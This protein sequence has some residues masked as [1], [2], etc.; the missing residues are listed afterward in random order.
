MTL[1]KKATPSQMDA[2]QGWVRSLTWKEMQPAMALLFHAQQLEYDLLREMIH[3]QVPP[4][5]PIHARAVPY[6]PASANACEDGRLV[7]RRHRFKRPRL[8]QWRRHGQLPPRNKQQQFA[9]QARKFVQPDGER[10]SLGCTWEQREADVALVEQSVFCESSS[11]SNNVV[12]LELVMPIV[13]GDKDDDPA[14]T[15]RR[16]LT[17]ASRGH[18]MSAA[19]TTGKNATRGGVW[20]SPW[21]DPTQ[22]WFSLPM[23]LASR[24]ELALWDAFWN[25]ATRRKSHPT[26]M[27]WPPDIHMLLS[28]TDIEWAVVQAVRQELQRDVRQ[29]DL[30]VLM[31]G[32]VWSFLNDNSKGCH[33]H[34][35]S[36]LQA[37]GSCPLTEIDTPREHIRLAARRAIQERYVAAAQSSLLLQEEEEAPKEKKNARRRKKR[38]K[39]RN[40]AKA[41]RAAPAPIERQQHQPDHVLTTSSSDEASTVDDDAIQFP[42][43]DTPIRERNRN[44][45][46]ALAIMD[47]VLTAVF[48]QVDCDDSL[49]GSALF[50]DDDEQEEDPIE[51]QI[52]D[53]PPAI[54]AGVSHEEP[55]TTPSIFAKSSASSSCQ[56]E[57]SKDSQSTRSPTLSP[58][59]LS[60]S[61]LCDTRKDSSAPKEQPN[62]LKLP[63]VRSLSSVSVL[64]LP[65]AADLRNSHHQ[66]LSVHD[67]AS[68]IH[69]PPRVGGDKDERT[70]TLPVGNDAED[71]TSIRE[72]RDAYRDMC[73]TMGAEVAKLKNMLAAQKSITLTV[74][75]SPAHH[76]FYHRSAASFDPESMPSPAFDIVPRA[77]TLAAMSD[78]GYLRGEHESQASEDD[79]VRLL[80][81]ER[82]RPSSG[83]TLAGSD[84]SLD[85]NG[86]HHV[87]PS[88]TGVSVT[89]VSYDPMSLLHGGMQ[90]RLTRDMQHFLE[91]VKVQLQ[92]QDPLRQA[93]IVRMTRLVKTVWPRAQVKLYGSLVTGLSLPSSDLDFVICLP[94][95]HKN[96]LAVAPGVLEGQNAI[97]QTSQKLLARTLSGELWVDARSMKLIERTPVPVIKVSTKA[98]RGRAL[99]LDITFD[100][101]GHHGLEAV[102][103]ISQLV[104]ELPMLRPLA[105]VLKQFLSHR[106]LLTSYTGGLSSYGLLLMI[107]RYLQEQPSSWGDMGSLLMGF[108][109]FYGNNVSSLWADPINAL[110][111][112]SLTHFLVCPSLTLDPRESVFDT[113]DTFQGKLVQDPYT[114]THQ[115]PC[116]LRGDHLDLQLVRRLLSGETAFVW[117]SNRTSL[118]SHC[119][120]RWTLCGWRTP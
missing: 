53:D 118:S 64:S 108:L 47:Q 77:R 95:V 18:F 79:A 104:E 105:I 63:S 62:S 119:R 51:E 54:P 68:A 94:A 97:K 117:M 73:L 55:L 43:N 112:V 76:H 44:I 28:E 92:Q 102:L 83:V 25:S 111:L 13:G 69:S 35:N 115:R 27:S 10:L 114:V 91:E 8:L 81:T 70:T 56:E 45:V 90:S 110:S 4:P 100:S 103:L 6:A 61:S 19:H 99:Q 1:S 46:N 37:V 96:A 50:P 60:L 32:M 88:A 75:Y 11:S 71:P 98:S 82:Q 93:A 31:D 57:R 17:V 58:I 39:K 113:G 3:L 5:T 65:G 74:E 66:F 80:R 29:L 116:N 9:V 14:P 86:S 26:T 120:I 52:H 15:V 41:K 67:T 107:A 21:L 24:F 42:D 23:Y 72:E 87:L 33:T 59:Q 22:Q 12:R 89:R 7:P 38:R 30:A 34:S 84:V 85:P 48:E 109:D 78:A 2:F 16:W 36:L 40:A 20:Q 101:P 106:G 49:A